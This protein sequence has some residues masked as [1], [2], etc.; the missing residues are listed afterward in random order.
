MKPGI[1]KLLHP[2]LSLSQLIIIVFNAFDYIGIKH[3]ENL[4]PRLESNRDLELRRLLYYP[5]P[6]GHGRAGIVLRGQLHFQPGANP[7]LIE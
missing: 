7:I 6:T 2:G 1:N 3:T 5:R 4:W